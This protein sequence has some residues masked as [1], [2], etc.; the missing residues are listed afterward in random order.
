[1]Y[2][3][4]NHNDSCLKVLYI[5]LYIKDPII[6]QASYVQGKYHMHTFPNPDFLEVV[7]K[8]TMQDSFKVL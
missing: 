4:L 5:P 8:I 1:M 3:A 7:K 6:I 2:S